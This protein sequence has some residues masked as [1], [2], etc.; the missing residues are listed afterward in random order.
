MSWDQSLPHG[1]LMITLNFQ[2]TA[3]EPVSPL[4]LVVWHRL[5]CHALVNGIPDEG[6]AEVFESLHDAWRFYRSKP[7][8]P[9]LLE[10]VHEGPARIVEVWEPPVFQATEE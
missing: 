4:P 2:Q 10:T 5:L 7:S 6:L 3:A 8:A 1:R 9:R